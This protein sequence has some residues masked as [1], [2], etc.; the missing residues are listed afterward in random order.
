[1]KYPIAPYQKQKVEQ[2][3]R[4]HVLLKMQ[5]LNDQLN[6][7]RY[8]ICGYCKHKRLCTKARRVINREYHNC[9]DWK[10]PS[11]QWRRSK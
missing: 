9:L 3:Q 11:R 6:F 4:L 7:E 10:P 1:M 8:G 2:D 5:L